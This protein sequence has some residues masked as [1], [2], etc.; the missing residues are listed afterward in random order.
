MLNPTDK[1]V[2]SL[3]AHFGSVNLLL[4]IAGLTLKTSCLV[5]DVLQNHKEISIKAREIHLHSGSTGLEGHDE[6]VLL[7]RE[8]GMDFNDGAALANCLVDVRL[9]NG[10]L[11]LVLL[12][13]LTKLGAL[14]V[15]L[16]ERGID[17]KSGHGNLMR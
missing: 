16:R 1:V 4:K 7:S 17:F 8:L 13:V 2:L 10:N 9:R 5:N 11:L 15:G 6:L 3:D 12:L 14:E